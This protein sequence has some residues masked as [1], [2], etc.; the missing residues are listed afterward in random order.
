MTAMN[1]TSHT[2][3]NPVSV[4]VLRG[5]GKLSFHKTVGISFPSVTFVDIGLEGI[6][7]GHSSRHRRTNHAN[8]LDVEQ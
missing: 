1:R 3:R 4:G 6:S 5:W 8:K 7:W 2:R